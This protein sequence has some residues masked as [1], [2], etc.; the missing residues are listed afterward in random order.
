MKNASSTHEEEQ[1][2]EDETQINTQTSVSMI[3]T[4]VNDDLSLE[5]T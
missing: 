5:R 2:A 4:T 1:K 3:D